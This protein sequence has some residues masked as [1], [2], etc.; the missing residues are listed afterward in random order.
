MVVGHMSKHTP[1]VKCFLFQWDRQEERGGERAIRGH[2]PY[3][4][5][6]VQKTNTVQWQNT[7]IV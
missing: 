2:G 6:V 4:E 5:Q 7:P 1:Q 3:L